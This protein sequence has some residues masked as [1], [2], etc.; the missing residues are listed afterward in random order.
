MNWWGSFQLVCLI[1]AIIALTYTVLQP[2]LDSGLRLSAGI[3]LGIIML[4]LLNIYIKA[5]K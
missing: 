3:F 1:V 5:N 2:G 4:G